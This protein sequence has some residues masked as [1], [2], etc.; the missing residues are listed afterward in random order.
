MRTDI[1]NSCSSLRTPAANSIVHHPVNSTDHPRP[2]ICLDHH[3]RASGSHINHSKRRIWRSSL[4]VVPMRK[5][6]GK[7]RAR[8]NSNTN[9]NHN[10]LM[11]QRKSS[12]I[13]LVL[14]A[15][16]TFFWK[17]M[18]IL[19]SSLQYCPETTAIAIMASCTA[20]AIVKMVATTTQLVID[21][22]TLN[23]HHPA[24]HNKHHQLHHR[25]LA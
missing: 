12:H 15:R 21:T 3:Q 2:R 22:Q 5:M 24:I 17:T 11:D 20:M 16:R 1:C 6:K 25:L 23:R 7:E 10:R 18:L 9:S 13:R 4:G 14:T 19:I 8:D